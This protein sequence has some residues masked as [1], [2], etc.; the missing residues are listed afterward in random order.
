[1][2]PQYQD[3]IEKDCKE[4]F[5]LL[6]VLG[7]NILYLS[8]W[9]VAGWIVWPVQWHG[10]P[11]ATIFWAC[12]VLA[13]QVLLKKH[14]CSGCYYYGKACHLGWGKLSAWLFAQDSGDMKIGI[15]LSLFYIISPPLILV[16]GILIGILMD[17]GIRHWVLLGVYVGLNVVSFPVRMKGCRVCAM[18]KV[19]PGSAAKS[20]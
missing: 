11:V 3:K 10:W 13:V 20:A 9:I 16:A 2:Y 6:W 7:E 17:A 5:S 12:V 1:M 15:R 14:N 19:C 18:R 4:S 8:T